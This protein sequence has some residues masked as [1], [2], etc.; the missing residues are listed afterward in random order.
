MSSSN[1][2]IKGV[3]WTTILN[4]V[5]AVYGFISVPLLIN[6]F[7]KSEYGIIGLAMSVNVYMQ[8]MDLGFNSTNVRFF[9]SWL[10]SGLT[11]KVS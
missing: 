2:I 8:L 7:G 5:N 4:V 1:S 6:H 3:Y 11:D 10:T 9:S